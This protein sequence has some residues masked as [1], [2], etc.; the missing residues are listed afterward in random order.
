MW[1]GG[2]GVHAQVASNRPACSHFALLPDGPG[3]GIHSLALS[4][5]GDEVTHTSDP[6]V[7]PV[8]S[9]LVGDG[10]GSRR[11]VTPEG[12]VPPEEQLVRVRVA[13]KIGSSPLRRHHCR[14]VTA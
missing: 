7:L 6:G 11:W 8:G 2:W 1:S 13:T 9:V 14:L 12:V 5:P 3:R 10:P 4:L